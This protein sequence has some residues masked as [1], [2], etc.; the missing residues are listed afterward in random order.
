MRLTVS[1]L[2]KFDLCA[3]FF[4]SSRRRHTRWTGYWSSD[5]CSSDLR[6]RVWP[7][8]SAVPGGTPMRFIWTF[9]KVVIALALLV[10]ISIIALATALGILGALIGVAILSLKIRSEERRVGKEGDVHI[11]GAQLTH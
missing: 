6:S 2:K 9:L 3:A 5:V 1:L 8:L 4:F 11:T 10:P 7:I